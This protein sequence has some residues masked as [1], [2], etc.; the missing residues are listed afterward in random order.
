MFPLP[1]RRSLQRAALA[2]LAGAAL[3]AVGSVPAI[4]AG[5]VQDRNLRMV[6]GNCLLCHGA[7]GAANGMPALEGQDAKAIATAMREFKEGKRHGTIM[8]RI[9]KGYDDAVIE[10]L[11]AYLAAAKQ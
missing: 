2:G 9:A 8:P 10:A 11:S 1:A 6:A 7:A 4:A 3:L 5:P